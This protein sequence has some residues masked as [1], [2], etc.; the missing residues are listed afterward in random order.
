MNHHERPLTLPACNVNAIALSGVRSAGVPRTSRLLS[1]LGVAFCAVLIMLSSANKASAQFGDVT[2][3]NNTIVSGSSGSTPSTTLTWS[4]NVPA[5]S[6]RLLV[7]TIAIHR[8]AGV[9]ATTNSVTFGGVGLTQISAAAGNSQDNSKRTEIW[10]L[11]APAI[12]T[13]T[14]IVNLSSAANVVGASY[15]WASVDQSAPV[16]NAG[17]NAAV[18][19]P[20]AAAAVLAI[21][22]SAFLQSGIVDVVATEATNTA[23]PAAGQLN[24]HSQ[25]TTD[26]NAGDNLLG[27]GGDRDPPS[28]QFNVQQYNLGATDFWVMS[29]LT[30]NPAAL[31]S[32]G[33]ESVEAAAY[34]RVTLTGRSGGVLVNWRT[35]N[36]AN[37]LGYRLYRERD[38]KR[39]SVSKDIIAGSSL[40][41]AASLSSGYRYGWYDADGQAG[42]NYWLEDI[43]LAGN[44]TLHGPYAPTVTNAY[45]P[46]WPNPELPWNA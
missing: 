12:S 7:V 43:D 11:V 31:T 2:L 39:V 38:G 36:E 45:C 37:N 4:H 19:T 42:D 29:T 35:G 1:A 10:V 40:F 3:Y 20:S 21:C 16:F 15:S 32:A 30:L 26:S 9:L 27:R 17:N 22:P 34:D 6:N 8:T 28:G 5:S 33:L 18:N 23:T 24:V 25:T 41:S 13:G 44:T 46:N 14:I